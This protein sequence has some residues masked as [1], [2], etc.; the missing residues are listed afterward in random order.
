M[1]IDGRPAE[2]GDA[3]SRAI[4]RKRPGDMIEL[5]LFRNGRRQNIRVKLGEA[6]EEQL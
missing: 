3:I 2:R 6:P 5:T 4:G 1:A